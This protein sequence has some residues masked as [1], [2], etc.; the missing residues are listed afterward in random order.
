[1]SITTDIRRTVDEALASLA[2]PKPLL[3]VAGA[4]DLLVDRVRTAAAAEQKALESFRLDVSAVPVFVSATMDN[5]RGAIVGFPDHA[6]EP[7]SYDDLAARGAVLVRRVRLQQ[8]SKDLGNQ[9]ENAVRAAR[10]ASTTARHATATTTSRTKAAATSAGKAAT[11]AG[12]AV[13]AAGAKIGTTTSTRVRKANPTRKSASRPATASAG[14]SAPAKPTT[15]T[16]DTE[17]KD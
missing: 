17:P 12:A 4:G 10:A 5:L 8:A 2:D 7:H 1:M 9:F 11:A 16:K 6:P 15:T 3:A 14:P 13:T